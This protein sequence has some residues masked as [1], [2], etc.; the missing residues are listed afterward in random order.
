MI[1]DSSVK[2]IYFSQTKKQFEL[3]DRQ[4]VNQAFP[5]VF[6]SPFATHDGNLGTDD[7]RSIP[8]RARC[9]AH[10]RLPAR[11]EYV[12]RRRTLVYLKVD[13]GR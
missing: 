7:G 9:N 2:F 4:T 5:S 10:V 12:S 8:P 13:C 1:S 3:L 6:V 11:V